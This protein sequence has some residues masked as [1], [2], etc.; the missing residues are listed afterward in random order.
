MARILLADDD[1]E[2]GDMLAEYLGKEGFEVDVAH[3]GDAAL[4]KALTNPY[5]LLI[6]DVMMP[7]RNGFDVLREV[8]ARSFLPVLMLTARGDDIDSIVGLELGADDYLTKP[9]SPR[10]LVA[11]IRAILR[12]AEAQST[13]DGFDQIALNDIVMNAGARTVTCDDVPVSMTSTEFSVLAVLL[14]EAG[15]IVTKA[16]LSERALGRKLSRYDRSL[17]MHVSNLRKK[18]GPLPDGQERIKT[19]RGVGYIYSRA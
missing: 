14:R 5:D 1:H 2:L 3:D 8:R 11:R 6:L 7:G 19:V 4:S 10:V 17:D 15:N 9:S 16:I 18:L 12:R 13:S